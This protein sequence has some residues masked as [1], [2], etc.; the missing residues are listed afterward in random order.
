MELKDLLVKRRSCRC[1]SGEK[2]E[3]EILKRIIEKAMLA[4]SACNSQPWFLTAVNDPEKVKEI[5]KATHIFGSNA[6]SEKAGAFIVIEQREAKL[7]DGVVKLVGSKYFADNDIGIITGY[8]TLSAFDEGVESCVLGLFD[9]KAVKKA[10]G[11]DK[12]AEIKL[13]LCLGYAGENDK[14]WD[15]KRKSLEEVSK[16]M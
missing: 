15:K 8:L 11:M 7:K 16:F 3:T 10:L 14:V 9:K 4:P 2:V 6:F 12:N 13:L 1:Y 5:A